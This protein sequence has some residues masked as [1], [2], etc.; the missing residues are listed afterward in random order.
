MSGVVDATREKKLLAAYTLYADV[1]FLAPQTATSRVSDELLPVVEDPERISEFDVCRLVLDVLRKGAVAARDML[2]LE[3]NKM[4][5][6]GCLLV[7]LFVDSD[8][9]RDALAALARRTASAIQKTAIDRV[10]IGPTPADD[11]EPNTPIYVHVETPLPDLNEETSS[12]VGDSSSD[13]DEQTDDFLGDGVH[14]EISSDDEPTAQIRRHSINTIMVLHLLFWHLLFHHILLHLSLTMDR[15]ACPHSILEFHMPQH[16]Y[17]GYLSLK[18]QCN[19]GTTSFTSAL[20]VFF[21]CLEVQFLSTPGDY[22]LETAVKMFLPSRMGFSP[23][24]CRMI[25]AP[26][27]LDDSRA[28]CL[29][30]FDM[31][32]KILNIMDPVHTLQD[33]EVMAG[34][35]ATN[36]ELLLAGLGEVGLALV[37]GFTINR[38][39]WDIEY[40]IGINNPCSLNESGVYLFHYTRNFTGANLAEQIDEDGLVVLRRKLFYDI[41]AMDG[42]AGE[43]PGFMER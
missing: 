28:W 5:V 37:E 34:L 19:V 6:P 10:N 18:M 27:P 15:L 21:V 20:I 22:D 2:L 14:Y 24:T 38:D 12:V 32:A 11:V 41:M 13:S 23:A 40:N 26:V 1:V 7:P 42:N 16:Q 25:M 31:H 17:I 4:I 3:P 43:T 33:Q 29:Y 8:A 39:E 36:A 9:G 30:A 35:H